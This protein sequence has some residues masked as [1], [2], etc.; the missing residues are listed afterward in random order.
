MNGSKP[1]RSSSRC[2]RA[3]LSKDPPWLAP[4]CVG[5]SWLATHEVGGC[6]VCFLGDPLQLRKDTIQHDMLEN[7]M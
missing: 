6:S 5:N 2:R 7:A 3:F 4:L 1:Y